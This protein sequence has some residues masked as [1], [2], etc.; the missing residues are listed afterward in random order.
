[1]NEKQRPLNV[2]ISKD[3]VE[4][5]VRNLKNNKASGKDRITGELIICTR[6]SERKIMKYI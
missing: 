3:E 2:P 5:P 4:K 6:Y 1:M